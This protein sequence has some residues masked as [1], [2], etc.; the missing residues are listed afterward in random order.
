M[1]AFY[2]SSSLHYLSLQGFCGK[3]FWFTKHEAKLCCYKDVCYNGNTLLC[4]KIIECY[5]A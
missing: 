5:T 4:I 3:H 1:L 2:F